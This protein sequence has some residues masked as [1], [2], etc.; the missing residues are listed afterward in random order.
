MCCASGRAAWPERDAAAVPALQLIQINN[1][2]AGAAW[3]FTRMAH[4]AILPAMQALYRFLLMLLF[5]LPALNVL[6][7]GGGVG[8]AN[9]AAMSA[10]CAGH[11]SHASCHQEA[12]VG[13]ASHASQAQPA[14]GMSCAA[15]ACALHC[16]P[17]LLTQQTSLP[18]LLPH[19]GMFIPTQPAMLAGITLPP[20]QRPPAAV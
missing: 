3:R 9:P 17:V 5:A 14:H 16:A 15:A 11:A 12:T 6:A 7:A 2:A 13:P 8:M 18:G 19:C 10:D 20:P 4:G 1:A